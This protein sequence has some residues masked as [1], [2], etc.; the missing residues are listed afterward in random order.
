MTNQVMIVQE[1]DPYVP[2]PNLLA[3]N[4]ATAV[5]LIIILL[6]IWSLDESGSDGEEGGS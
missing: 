2:R 3:A 1:L 6:V 4:I 5:M